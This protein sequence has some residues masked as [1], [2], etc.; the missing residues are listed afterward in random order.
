M[1]LGNSVLE[2]VS[3]VFALYYLH[4]MWSYRRW[5]ISLLLCVYYMCDVTKHYKFLSFVDF[6]EASLGRILNI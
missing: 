3:L 2:N 4:A 6:T 1:P 5:F